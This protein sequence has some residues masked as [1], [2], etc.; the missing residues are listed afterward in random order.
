MGTRKKILGLIDKGYND[1]VNV[2]QNVKE[3]TVCRSDEEVIREWLGKFEDVLDK[4]KD[5]IES[6]PK[7]GRL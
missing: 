2:S 5:E 6:V 7:E 1:I 4:I 3:F